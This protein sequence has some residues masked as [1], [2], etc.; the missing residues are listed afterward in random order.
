ME[1]EDDEEHTTPRRPEP[2]AYAPPLTAMDGEEDRFSCWYRRYGTLMRS[3][4]EKVLLTADAEM[5]QDTGTSGR[6]LH[7]I[8]LTGERPSV[9]TMLAEGTAADDTADVFTVDDV[10]EG[11]NVT[12]HH[13]SLV[14]QASAMPLAPHALR[15]VILAS[16]PLLVVGRG[17]KAGH[18]HAGELLEIVEQHLASGKAAGMTYGELVES[19]KATATDMLYQ[20]FWCTYKAQFPGAVAAALSTK[21]GGALR[22]AAK[23]RMHYGPSHLAL[24]CA[25]NLVGHAAHERQ[26]RAKCP[27]QVAMNPLHAKGGEETNERIPSREFLLDTAN[28][29][30]L[31][32]TRA[33]QA[34]NQAQIQHNYL[35]GEETPLSAANGLLIRDKVLDDKLSDHFA[36]V[37]GV[38]CTTRSARK[39]CHTA[40]AAAHA[41]PMEE[42]RLFSLVPGA[43]AVSVADNV[44]FGAIDARGGGQHPMAWLLK[45]TFDEDPH[46]NEAY[47]DA[48]A[49]SHLKASSKPVATRV[50]AVKKRDTVPLMKRSVNPPAAA[51]RPPRKTV[52]ERAGSSFSLAVG[53]TAE[54]FLAEYFPKSFGTWLPTATAGDDYTEV[55]KALVQAA[56]AM[57]DWQAVL[58][59]SKPLAAKYP[60]HRTLHRADAAI[61]EERRVGS[62]GRTTSRPNEELAYAFATHTIGIEGTSR[63]GD[64][65]KKTCQDD[66]KPLHQV[67]VPM[68]PML[69][70]AT[71]DKAM[72]LTMLQTIEVMDVLGQ[73]AG[74]LVVDGGLF[75]KAC[76]MVWADS[77][78]RK[79]ILVSNGDFHLTKTACAAISNITK[80]SGIAQ[81]LVEAGAFDG[82][83]SAEHALSG[84]HVDNA[85]VGYSHIYLGLHGLLIDKWHNEELE[86]EEEEEEEIEDSAEGESDDHKITRAEL[87][88]VKAALADVN[89]GG[90]AGVAASAVGS[91]LGTHLERYRGFLERLST[92]TGNAAVWVEVLRWIEL[93]LRHRRI[94]RSPEGIP[95]YVAC[96]ETLHAL[97]CL[98]DRTVY[99]K[100]LAVQIA[101]WA[102]MAE[103]FP[104]LLGHG[105]DHRWL[106]S[107][108][109]TRFNGAG[110]EHDLIIEHA[111]KIIK[112]GKGGITKLASYD[113]HL[114]AWFASSSYRRQMSAMA[115]KFAPVTRRDLGNGTMGRVELRRNRAGREIKELNTLRELLAT[116]LGR[117]PFASA[118]GPLLAAMSSAR[119]EEEAKQVSRL[120]TGAALLDKTAASLL[121]AW[122][123]GCRRAHTMLDR[124]ALAAPGETG[125]VIWSHATLLRVGKFATA[126]AKGVKKERAADEMV[127]S[128]FFYLFHLVAS[129]V[130]LGDAAV[131]IPELLQHG[132]TT[133]GAGALFKPNGGMRSGDKSDW[134]T[135]VLGEP[136]QQ[137]PTR[138]AKGSLVIWDFMAKVRCLGVWTKFDVVTFYS[139]A[140][141]VLEGIVTETIRLGFEYGGVVVDQY[142]D[143]NA[144]YCPL[145]DKAQKENRG[146][147]AVKIHEVTEEGRLGS[148]A[149]LYD[150]LRDSGHKHKFVKLLKEALA[151]VMTK[152]GPAKLSGFYM[153]VE[154]RGYLIAPGG[155]SPRRT[156]STSSSWK[157]TWAAY[158]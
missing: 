18:K 21:I 52:L 29:G 113:S 75:K 64:H 151:A 46:Q 35:T 36:R 99:A 7:Y 77:R 106:L 101:Q 12:M 149:M 39:Q 94:M 130:D 144:Q 124:V 114:V 84:G 51:H 50:P 48:L 120:T 61:M 54:V 86:E 127:G 13:A 25:L 119:R 131:S 85:L 121:C 156:V 9:A 90:E 148:R 19:D 105:A 5:W 44:D 143:D 126:T 30:K 109:D 34:L 26:H 153:I 41:D 47:L 11:E 53:S 150:F 112:N 74:L 111:N 38:S 79:R 72:T 71:S 134:A 158:G 22:A 91:R 24:E 116:K 139:V 45:L 135:L 16:P 49:K 55:V 10:L 80:E 140:K 43:R 63:I 81:M 20:R 96:L 107:A 97:C 154:G 129:G 123:Q 95:E 27:A 92:R 83:V 122:E 42:I 157:Q 40:A 4:L 104:S 133:G 1:L 93:M 118:D 117:N 146:G 60:G 17:G 68:I 102:T 142:S 147:S 76:D 23:P 14:A 56:G 69:H 31:A 98:A 59:A 62:A 110:K 65:R 108:N 78:F 125:V 136:L 3:H 57:Q 87:I 145:K 115:A 128:L 155:G 137:P 100:G 2:E 67:M 32:H 28:E 6:K 88:E 82:T 138:P 73:E 66:E 33:V 103:C 89:K 152:V 141:A 58:R 70:P 8:S 15:H 132:L 37:G